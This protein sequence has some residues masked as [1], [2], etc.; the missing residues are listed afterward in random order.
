LLVVRW[1]LQRY[2]DGMTVIDTAALPSDPLV[3]LQQLATSATELDRVR[4]RLVADARQ[5]GASWAKIGAALGMSRQAA[6]EYFSK[7]AAERLA[8]TARSSGLSEDEAMQ[9]AVEEV[10]AVRQSG[11][12]R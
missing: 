3:A 4:D 8:A 10:R 9:I 11:R 7:R 2:L 12:A 1:Q 6:W 5:A